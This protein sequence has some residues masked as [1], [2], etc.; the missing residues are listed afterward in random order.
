MLRFSDRIADYFSAFS[1]LWRV[2][3]AE[4]DRKQDDQRAAP[5]ARSFVTGAVITA[6]RYRAA[7]VAAGTDDG[8]LIDKIMQEAG[9]VIFLNGR[10]ILFGCLL[11][12]DEKSKNAFYHWRRSQSRS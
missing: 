9:V 12:H 4:Q 8:G 7:S 10:T 5:P 6:C 1:V 11:E 2:K 3:T